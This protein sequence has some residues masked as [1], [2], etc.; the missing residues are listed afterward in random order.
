MLQLFLRRYN[1]NTGCAR[2][3]LEDRFP[4]APVAGLMSPPFRAL[5]DDEEA[6]H[7]AAINA[8]GADV[9]WV[10]LGCPKQERWI[11][12]NRSRLTI[13]LAI[14]VGAAFRFHSGLVQ[15]SPQWI[16]DAGLECVWRLAVEP[17]KM[18]KRDIIDGPRFIAAALA[19]LWSVRVPAVRR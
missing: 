1:C 18:W 10:G 14:G 11:A 7:V 9:L 6:E 4:G 19:D 17:R 3:R 2:K 16:G 13:P 5:S 15:R 12:R 8:S